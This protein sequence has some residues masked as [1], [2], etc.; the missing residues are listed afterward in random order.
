MAAVI[1]FFAD[2]KTAARIR[3]IAAAEDRS[4]SQVVR[5]ALAACGAFQDGAE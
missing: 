1:S 4:V 3:E 2:D 5:R